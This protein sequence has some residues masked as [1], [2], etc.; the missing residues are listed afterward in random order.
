MQVPT[1]IGPGER[2][3]TELRKYVRPGKQ[4]LCTACGIQKM[5]EQQR[6]FHEGNHPSLHKSIAAGVESGR[7]MR[8]RSG[9]IYERWVGGMMARAQ[10]EY[11]E[12]M[13]GRATVPPTKPT[14]QGRRTRRK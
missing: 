5:V 3:G 4:A 1:F 13:K 2:C 12:M 8:E 6:G 10:L 11:T 9:P 7:Q 14:G